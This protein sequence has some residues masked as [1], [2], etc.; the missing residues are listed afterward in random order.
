MTATPDVAF[1]FRASGDGGRGWHWEEY[2]MSRKTHLDGASRNFAMGAALALAIIGG[3]SVPAAFA[4]EQLRLGALPSATGPGA[5]IGAALTAGV[6]LAVSEINEA[7]GVLGRKIEIVRGDTQ[8]NPTTAASEARRLIE[9]EGI[10]ILIGPLISQ[11]AVPAVE[12]ATAGKVVQITNA[13]TTALTP[14]VGPYHFSFGTSA[15]T[16]AKVIVDYIVDELKVESIGLL[17]DDGGQSRSAVAEVKKN[18]EARGIQLA[19][20]QEYRFRADDLSPQVL[21]LR[22]ADPEVVIFFTST[23]DDGVKFLGTTTQVGWLP[24]IVGAAAVSVYAPAIARSVPAEAFENVYSV[25]Y[26]GL[27]Y[28]SSDAEGTSAYADFSNKLKAFA[29]DV[30]EKISVS[31]ASEYYDSVKLLMAGVEATGETGGEALAKWVESDGSKVPLIHGAISPSSES[32]F[33]FGPNELAIVHRPNDIRADG[34]MKRA[35][36]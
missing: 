29:P 34:L 2:T 5:S 11:E 9:R 22:R 35:G 27:T 10:E 15:A 19:V 16:A 26:K 17:A 25:A 6:E 28:C 4:Q 33:L 13:G 31:L 24:K 36:C 21:S 8:S 32:H 7:G 1:S 23:V 3:A 14:E 30:Y 12:V 18:L 20:E